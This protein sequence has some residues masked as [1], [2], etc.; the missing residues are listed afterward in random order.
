MG[1]NPMRGEV[2]IVIDG[3][4]R[5]MRLSLGALAGLEARL[6]AG[7]LVGLAER[8]ENGTV[9]TDD[10]IA[11][12]AA[13]LQGAGEEVTEMELM[14]ADIA[15]GAVGALHAGVRLLARSFRPEGGVGP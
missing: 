5:R 2:A 13:G 12:L 14:T 10:L 11:L 9:A 3:V 15:G 6:G 7:S 1:V 4:E 8:F